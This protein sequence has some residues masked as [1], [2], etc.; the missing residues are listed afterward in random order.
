VNA[1]TA[2]VLVV[3]DNALVSSAM[4]ILLEDAGF[5]VS[6]AARLAEAIDVSRRDRPDVILLDLRLPDGDGLTLID[7]LARH[8]IPRPIVAGLTGR[9]EPEVRARCLA[10]G[11]VDVLVKPVNVRTL[12]PL[13]RSWLPSETSGA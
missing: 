2:H 3:E 5:R 6:T 12:A 8:E 7:Q 10:A 4:I 9:D 11:C 1:R 13:V